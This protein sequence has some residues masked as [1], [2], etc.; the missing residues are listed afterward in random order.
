MLKKVKTPE[1][2]RRAQKYRCKL[3]C[4]RAL[5]K[6]KVRMKQASKKREWE[7]LAAIGDTS[8]RQELIWLAMEHGKPIPVFSV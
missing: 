4:E 6:M 1:Q 8:A 2:E 7:R 3:I 5:I